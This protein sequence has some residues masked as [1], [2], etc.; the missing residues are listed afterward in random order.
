MNTPLW[1]TAQG[2]IFEGRGNVTASDD[3][4]G[5][6]SVLIRNL[7]RVYDWMDAD[8]QEAI[9]QYVNIQYWSLV[10]YDSNDPAQP[11]Q[12]GRNWTGPSFEVATGQDMV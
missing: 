9:T 3:G 5:F 8:V 4:I 12:Y 1:N 10:N 7:H 2:A 6:K 11:M